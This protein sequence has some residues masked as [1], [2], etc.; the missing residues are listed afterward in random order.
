MDKKEIII[1]VIKVLIYALGLIAAAFGVSA[2]TSCTT[3]QH[4]YKSD[5]RTV[6]IT[7][8]TTIVHHDGALSI[9]LK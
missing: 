4:T 3:A 5:G 9:K 8:D 7:N 1:I 6:I 2:I